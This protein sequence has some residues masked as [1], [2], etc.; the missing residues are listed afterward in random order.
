MYVHTY[1]HACCTTTYNLK[2]AYKS[3]NC[4]LTSLAVQCSYLYFLCNV[5]GG[6]S[7]DLHCSPCHRTLAELSHKVEF[8]TKEFNRLQEKLEQNYK[9]ELVQREETIKARE[10]NLK[11]S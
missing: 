7:C 4:N 10:D 5:T 2:A 8:S 1:V 6:L 11:G 9:R 3:S